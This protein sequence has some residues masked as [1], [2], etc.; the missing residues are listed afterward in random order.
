LDRLRER[1]TEPRST[2]G[3]GGS[4]QAPADSDPVVV[5]PTVQVPTPAEAER[6]LA[7]EPEPSYE[8]SESA[9][10]DDFDENGIPD[11]VDE[12]EGRDPYGRPQDGITPSNPDEAAPLGSRRVVEMLRVALR[13]LHPS[14]L[15]AVVRD[16]NPGARPDVGGHSDEPRSVVRRVPLADEPDGHGRT[17]FVQRR[18]SVGP[19]ARPEPA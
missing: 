3:Q 13:T 9:A 1:A 15:G 11:W 12:L 2:S 19:G 5:L 8:E 7:E 16:P 4:G 6:A 17:E 10:Q 14:L 18:W